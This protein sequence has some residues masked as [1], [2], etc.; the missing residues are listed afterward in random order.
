M[1]VATL[2]GGAATIASTTSFLPQA[3][4]VI[5]TRDT[6][7]ISAGMYAVTVVGFA[8]WLTYGLLLGAL[9]LIVTN[10]ICLLL[11]AFILAMK[12]L[13]PRGKPAV[14]EALDPGG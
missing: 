5:R 6:A 4:K 14:A 11:S 8:L 1:D 12:L 3:W 7:A 13:P 9:P 2:V 10:G